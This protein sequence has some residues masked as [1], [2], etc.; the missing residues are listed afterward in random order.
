MKYKFVNRVSVLFSLVF[1]FNAFSYL[2][3]ITEAEKTRERL[4]ASFLD[5]SKKSLS[6]REDVN[7]LSEKVHD[8]KN[9]TSDKIHVCSNISESIEKTD[10]CSTF[11]MNSH[12][13][14]K[15][16]LSALSNNESKCSS[17]GVRKR[18]NVIKERLRGIK[19]RISIGL[20]SLAS[21]KK[22]S[23]SSEKQKEKNF[24]RYKPAHCSLLKG[25]DRVYLWDVRIVLAHDFGDLYTMNRGVKALE[26]LHDY[27]SNLYD[28]CDLQNATTQSEQSIASFFKMSLEDN[29]TSLRRA[30]ERF[31]GLTFEEASKKICKELEKRNAD[32]VGLCENPINS[33]SWLYSAHRFLHDT[34]E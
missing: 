28:I 20:E 8:L 34:F 22:L 7:Q 2:N 30:R 29:E 1:V 31:S 4:K 26:I 25:G 15:E 11:L 13:E 19:V 17:L 6:C 14:V 24:N 3:S 21:L 12:S 5:F 33:T 18:Y 9:T 32:I 16:L 27:M 23:V 10:Q